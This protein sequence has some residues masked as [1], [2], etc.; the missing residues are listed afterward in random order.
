MVFLYDGKGA[1]GTDIKGGAVR[2]IYS[3]I[4]EGDFGVDESFLLMAW[5]EGRRN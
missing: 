5:T 3:G 1:H 4:R 2:F